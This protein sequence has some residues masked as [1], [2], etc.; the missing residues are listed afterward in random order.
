MSNTITIGRNPSS[1][2]VVGSKYDTVS[3]DHAEIVQQGGELTFIDH[4]SNGT[5]I[6]GQKIH[7]KSVGI[8]QGDQILLAG[9]YEL[10]WV[11]IGRFVMPT[12]R[13]TVARNISGARTDGRTIKI[14]QAQG[15]H[16]RPTDLMAIR[17][18]RHTTELNDY[19]QPQEETVEHR[20]ERSQKDTS[21]QV[22][23]ELG[24]WNWGA[25]FFGWLWGI[26]NKVYIALIQLV[27][28]VFTFLLNVMGLKMIA[29]LF[30]LAT[31]GLSIWLGVKG[32]RMAWENR[33]YHNLEHFREVRHNWN[34][35]AAITAGVLLLLFVMSL[36]LFIDIITQLF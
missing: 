4:S 16:S 3:N 8:Y 30:S 20:R 28:I 22:E 36:L 27:I 32:S 12:G 15:G 5:V 17:Q 6:N 14:E 23:E 1:N 21:S 7:N 2:I 31:L 18:E 24:K 9:V 19:R 29:P 33:A 11:Q 25:F 10:D 13:P 34:V 35:A 26:F